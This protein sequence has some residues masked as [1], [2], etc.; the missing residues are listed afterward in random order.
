MRRVGLLTVPLILIALS[1][2]TSSAQGEGVFVDPDSPAGV[3]Y[4]IPLERARRDA[5]PTASD[6]QPSTQASAPLF[7]EG[8]T[9][10]ARGSS[11]DS[12]S[13]GGRSDRGQDESPRGAGGSDAQPAPAAPTA[14][15]GID[16]LATDAPGVLVI[17]A[18]AL[19]LALG[20]GGGIVLRRGTS[21]SRNP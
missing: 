13:E 6:A 16:K 3:Q 18:A 5:A 21:I 12:G 17:A 14:S 9:R 15:E 10:A 4:D 1:P 8:I 20:I 2:S 11:T 7:G 19:V